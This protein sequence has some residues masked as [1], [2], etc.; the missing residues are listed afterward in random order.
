MEEEPTLNENNYSAEAPNADIEPAT[1]QIN[2]PQSPMPSEPVIENKPP[3]ISDMIQPE[4]P[5]TTYE[6]HRPDATQSGLL[7]PAPVVQEVQPQEH[8]PGMIVLQWL[9]YAFW[10]WT[11][12][13]ISILIGIVL[14]SLLINGSDVGNA[15]IYSMA[16]VLVLLPI[17]VICDLFYMK[18]EPIKKE[19]AA[20][21][22]MIIHAVI[23]ALLAIGALVTLVFSLVTL[24]IS[25][26]QT[27]QTQVSLYTS[28]IV[29]SL[30]GL[31]FM[32][33]I[34][35]KFFVKF[36]K[37]FVVVMVVVVAATCAFAIIGPVNEARVTQNDK[38][39]VDNLYSIDSAVKDYV[40]NSNSLPT[41][42]ENLT[43]KGD[44]KKLVTD[45]LVEYKANTK[46]ASSTSDSE[47]YYYQ[48][49]VTYTKADTTSSRYYGSDLS[50]SDYESYPSTY[51]HPA[52]NV[53]YK[54]TAQKYN[55]AD[56]YSSY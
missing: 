42:L 9:T 19:K 44:E 34:L 50:G 39:I 23:F 3:V 49:C 33:T 53:C 37:M 17:S 22:I 47:S 2:P 35:P 5:K 13:A 4:P 14:N 10:G 38:L 24:F 45:K 48:L 6:N 20:S 15:P 31:V 30:Y 28:L 26:S 7:T 55:Y 27:E 54:L 32:R 12:V 40:N 51:G 29:A 56:K 18:H 16:A 25:A 36:R 11:I 8:G 43:L 46:A 1:E 52:G 41:S 21:V